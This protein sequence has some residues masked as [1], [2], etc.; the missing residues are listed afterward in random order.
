[1]AEQRSYFSRPYAPAWGILIGTAAG[2]PVG[3]ATD[4]LIITV[5]SLVGL[6]IGYVI[7]QG[8]KAQVEDK[9]APGDVESKLSQLEDL[10]SKSL[11]TE[12]EFQRKRAEIISR[13]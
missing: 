5:F 1:M 8:G 9:S 12:E 13:L 3:L 10:R 7:S 4:P 6:V 2:V 11:V